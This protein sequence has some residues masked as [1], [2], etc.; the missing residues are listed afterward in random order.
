MATIPGLLHNIAL[1]LIE[2][3]FCKTML[4]AA[5]SFAC[6]TLTAETPD[7]RQMRTID[8]YNIACL[9]DG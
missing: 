6:V 8:Q 1:G 7:T 9:T 5:V 3:V 4:A 2:P